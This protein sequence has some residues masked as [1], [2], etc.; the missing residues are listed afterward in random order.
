MTTAIRTIIT[1]TII[2]NTTT[3]ETGMTTIV[4]G[5]AFGITIGITTK[6]MT[7]GKMSASVNAIMNVGSVNTA[8][9]ATTEARFITDILAAIRVALDIPAAVTDIPAPSMDA[10]GMAAGMAAATEVARAGLATARAFRMVRI[11]LG[12]MWRKA[13]HSTHTREDQVIPIMGT[14][15]IWGTRM[16]IG[17]RTIRAT[18]LVINPTSAGVAEDGDSKITLG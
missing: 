10:V 11:R 8:T 3:T 14:T 12:K 2:T 4:V 6:E 18:V 17:R 13:S 9:M 5:Q 16:F 7:I 15:A 1:K